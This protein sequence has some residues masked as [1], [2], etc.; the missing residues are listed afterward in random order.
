VWVRVP[1]SAL[2]FF[3]HETS[4]QWTDSPFGEHNKTRTFFATEAQRTQRKNN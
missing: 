2:Y 1:P 3:P 4:R